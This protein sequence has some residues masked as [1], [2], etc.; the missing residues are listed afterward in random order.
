M[1]FEINRIDEAL[2]AEESRGNGELLNG[3]CNGKC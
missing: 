3:R 2:A 1:K